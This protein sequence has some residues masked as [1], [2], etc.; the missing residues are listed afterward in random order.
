METAIFRLVLYKNGNKQ[1]YSDVGKQRKSL[2][3]LFGGCNRVGLSRTLC[4]W[5][6]I[7]LLGLLLLLILLRLCL[8]CLLCLLS[9]LCLLVL[10]R[11]CLLVLLRLC[12]GLYGSSAGCAE[13]CVVVELLTAIFTKCHTISP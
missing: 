11:L 10:L 8:L 4:V 2:F 12:L 1:K 6:L 9:L 5:L 3:A 7:T 13:H